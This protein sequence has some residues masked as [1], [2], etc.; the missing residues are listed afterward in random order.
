VTEE[1]Y[2]EELRKA[3]GGPDVVGPLTAERAWS[4]FAAVTDLEVRYHHALR[5]IIEP[6]LGG[7]WRDIEV[8]TAG[9]EVI[10]GEQV[11]EHLME[12]VQLSTDRIT[13]LTTTGIMAVN[14][15]LSI[16]D[17]AE[18]DAKYPIETPYGIFP[19]PN[20]AKYTGDPLWMW[21]ER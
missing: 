2:R 15:A 7:A 4:R 14:S 12:M 16:P 1:Q 21:R 19:D 13:E 20:S 9:G 18:L 11:F 6:F 8:R 3:L 5:A 10:H 17:V